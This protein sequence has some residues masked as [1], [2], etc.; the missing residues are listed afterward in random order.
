MTP[1]WE[2]IIWGGQQKSTGEAVSPNPDVA[3][4]T[5]WNPVNVRPVMRVGIYPG[6]VSYEDQQPLITP[7][8]AVHM[9]TAPGQWGHLYRAGRLYG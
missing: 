4:K 8:G 9:E 6:I 2:R 3:Y 1:F 5:Q 7:D